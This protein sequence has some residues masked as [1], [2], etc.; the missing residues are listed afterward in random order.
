MSNRYTCQWYDAETKQ[1][2]TLYSDREWNRDRHQRDVHEKKEDEKHRQFE[3][4]L[5][6]NIFPGPRDPIFSNP[7][8]TAVHHR[9]G[10]SSV[11]TLLIPTLALNLPQGLAAL[12]DPKTLALVQEEAGR[13]RTIVA[14][15]LRKLYGPF[16]A[17]DAPREAILSGE[18]EQGEG[19]SLPQGRD[20]E[21]EVIV[22]VHAKPW[23]DLLHVHVMSKDMVSENLQHNSHYNSF[24]TRFF[25]RLDEFPLSQAQIR[26][27][28]RY[29]HSELQCWRCGV[30]FGNIVQLKKHLAAEHGAWKTE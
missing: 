23:M 7:S 3:E 11:H 19:E 14:R 15:E 27:R 26:G 1:L 12:Q 25:I 28:D 24:A 18:V 6:R 10:K 9:Y 21:K 20:W 22:G 4:D 16:S 29:L 13:L 8:A 5:S 30:G 2:C 17:Q